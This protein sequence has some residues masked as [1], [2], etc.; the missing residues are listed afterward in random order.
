M[1][2]PGYRENIER[3][4]NLFPDRV[5][6][7]VKECAGVLGVN[8]KTVYGLISRTHKNPIPTN[9]IGS[10]H[11]VIPIVGLVRWMSKR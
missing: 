7:S 8:I 6:I 5:T 2:L 3:L 11:R 9:L 4:D 10:R 1:E